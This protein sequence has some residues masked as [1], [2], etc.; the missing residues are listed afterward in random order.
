[1]ADVKA[2]LVM[3]DC[4]SVSSDVLD[5]GMSKLQKPRYS[6]DQY[7]VHNDGRYMQKIHENVPCIL[8]AC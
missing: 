8:L 4:L 7:L 6:W 3:S 1:M 5:Y 2:W